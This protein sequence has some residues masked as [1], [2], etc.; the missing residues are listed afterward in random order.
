[1]DR[2]L[3]HKRIY[4]L[5]KK[6]ILEYTMST[7]LVAINWFGRLVANNLIRLMLKQYL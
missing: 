7:V 4:L 2:R 3:G 1:M 6:I 5:Y